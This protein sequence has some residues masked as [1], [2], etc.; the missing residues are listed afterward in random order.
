HAGLVGAD[1]VRP[2]HGAG[3]GAAHQVAALVVVVVAGQHE[4]DAVLVEQR[5][6]ALADA[7]VGPVGVRSGHGRLVHHDDDPV[8]GPVGGRLAK[9]L[10][11]PFLL[12]AAGVAG[13]DLGVAGA[14]VGAG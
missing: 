14:Q 13:Q 11:Q 8:D 7:Q 1:H 9:R 10:F 3:V 6:P 2:Q 5:H 4:V 12:L